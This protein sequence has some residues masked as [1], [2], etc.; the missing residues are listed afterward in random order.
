MK[1]LITILF[2]ACILFSTNPLY[3]QTDTLTILHVNDTHSNLAPLDPPEGPY[4]PYTQGGIARAASLIGQ[5]QMTEPNVLTLHAGDVYIGDLFFNVFFG[6]AE[7]QLMNAMG[8][9]A[10]AVGNHEFDLTPYTL[11]QALDTAFVAGG[12]P[13]LSANLNIDDPTLI[14]LKNYI[15]SYTVKQVGNLKVGIFGL[16]TPE[17]NIL[18][19]PNPA[20]IDTNIVQIAANMVDTL[21]NQNCDVIICLSHLGFYLDQLV[22]SYVPGI[23]VIVGGHDHY[24]LDAPVEVTNPMG[25]P[26]W[27]V[28][29]D[30]FYKYIGKLQLTVSSGVVSLLDFNAIHLDQS[31]PEEP[32]IKSVVDGL[33]LDIEAI[34]GPV[35]SQTVDNANGH[36]FEIADSLLF[37]GYKDTPAGN[38][39]ADAFRDCTKTDIAIEPGGSI[40][41]PLYNGNVIGADIFRMVGYGFNTDNG[42]GYR[43][44]TFDIKGSD[45]WAGLEFGL[46]QIELNDEYLIQVSG[47][48]YI[49]NP[50]NQPFNR[51]LSVRIHGLPIDTTAYYSVTSNEFVSLFLNFLNIP[52]INLQ[53]YT[54]FTEYQVIEDYLS[55][56]NG[57]HPYQFGR[58]IAADN[59]YPDFWRQTTAPLSRKFQDIL[60]TSNGYLFAASEHSPTGIIRSVD[61]GITWEEK[62]NGLQFPMALSLAEEPNGDLYAGSWGIYRSTDNGE[63]WTATAFNFGAFFCFAFNQDSTTNYIFA[64]S[65]GGIFRS[66]DSGA[67]WDTTSNGLPRPTSVDVW[68]LAVTQSGKVYAGTNE[69]L[70][71][72]T[73][74]GDDWLLVDSIFYQARIRDIE[75]NSHGHIFIAESGRVF[76]SIDDGQNWVELSIPP[77]YSLTCALAINSLDHIFVGGYLKSTDNGNTWETLNTDLQT[78]NRSLCID[79]S[80]YLFVATSYDGIFKSVLSTLDTLTNIVEEK[81]KNIPLQFNLKQNYPNPFN[82]ETNIPLILAMRNHVVLEIFDILGRKVKTLFS[83]YMPAGKH[84]LLWNGKDDAGNQ[85]SSG[86]Y[87][88]R[89]KAGE[90]QVTRKMLLL[91]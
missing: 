75:I 43:I 38:L 32:S 17:T 54:G 8:F 30:A 82:P 15:D 87:L 41:Q 36:F 66:T 60:S 14:G 88:Y 90:Q 65:G 31:I 26:T 3:S 73:N 57:L 89:L 59:L 81:R 42:L 77:H 85:V 61:G 5:A 1:I 35:Y 62:N 53:I 56:M 71:A 19:Q 46:S 2:S 47:M 22:A 78:E 7:L 24:L 4:S 48:D 91:R 28:Q 10:M 72:S 52:Y 45:L 50:A 29:T 20:I 84:K 69:G 51:L 23:N 37:Y 13:L 63:N 9:D 49:Y 44:V 25:N 27:I 79:Q 39:I 18:S 33:I 34:Y 76:R 16:T 68:A 64:G 11:L 67:S 21:S 55:N 83:G 86:A 6:V 12:F 74:N 40:A 70:F 80:G 58:I